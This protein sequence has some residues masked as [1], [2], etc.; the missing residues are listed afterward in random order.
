LW[1]AADEHHA[2]AVILQADLTRK[3][4]P[5]LTKEYAVGETVTLLR[6]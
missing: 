3:H 6:S 2:A 1:D 5:F 4:R